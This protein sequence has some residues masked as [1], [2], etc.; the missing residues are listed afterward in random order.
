MFY[1]VFLVLVLLYSF[2]C[3]FHVDMQFCYMAFSSLNS[4]FYLVYYLMYL[5]MHPIYSDSLRC[6]R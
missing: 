2:N 4:N 1:S 3:Y 5:Y 6:F